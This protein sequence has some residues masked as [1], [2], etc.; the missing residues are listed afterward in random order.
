MRLLDA[1]I[2]SVNEMI[3]RIKEAHFGQYLFT[4]QSQYDLT[5]F[6]FG[7]DHRSI[8]INQ[9]SVSHREGSSVM[10]AVNMQSLDTMHHMH[11]KYLASK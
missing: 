2:T 9:K 10:S 4:Y 1:T 8:T 11:S 3:E 5:R 7:I 6:L